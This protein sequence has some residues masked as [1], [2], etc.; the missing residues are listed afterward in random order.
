MS[1]L[2]VGYGEDGRVIHGFTPPPPQKPY[3]RTQIHDKD[4]ISHITQQQNEFGHKQPP[5]K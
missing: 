1:V 4:T 2:A 5:P 3:T